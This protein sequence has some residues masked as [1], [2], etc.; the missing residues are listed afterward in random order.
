MAPSPD[1]REIVDRL[2]DA[3]KRLV[4]E[5]EW[6][7]DRDDVQRLTRV[8]ECGGELAAELTVKAYARRPQPC[9]RIVLTMSRAI[10][11]VDF[12]A[13]EPHVNP[14]LN[15]YT[16]VSPPR[17]II[18]GPHYHAWSDNRRFATAASLPRDLR[19]ARFIPDR[20]RTFEQAF[21]W[22]C[23]ETGIELGPE[24][25]FELPTRDTLL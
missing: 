18:R 1:I 15:R 14:R 11:R 5:G 13:N 10:W 3:T 25:L 20:I 4:G 8:V 21:R 2:L 23:H 24:D 7:P 6:R 9:F 12:V 17:G 22:F 19:L 16:E